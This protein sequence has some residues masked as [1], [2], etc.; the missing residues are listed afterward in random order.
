MKTTYIAP[1]AEAINLVAEVFICVSTTN[2]VS[3]NV[4]NPFSGNVPLEEEEW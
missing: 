3:S 2:G 4:G 1:Q